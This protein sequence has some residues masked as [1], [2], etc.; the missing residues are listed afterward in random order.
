MK[1]L[2]LFCC[3]VSATFG[4]CNTTCFDFLVRFEGYKTTPY[5]L[6][7]VWHVG[8]GHKFVVGE[9]IR[10]YT[11]EEVLAL[12]V[13]DVERAKRAAQRK[14]QSFYSHPEKI[15]LVLISLAYN[16]GDKGFE[17]FVK[18]RAAMERGDYAMAAKELENSLWFNQLP[19]RARHHIAVIKEFS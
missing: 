8:I 6:N 14:I 1:K 3:L 18:F 7:G 9:P 11:D 5:R 2:L 15:R 10:E 13:S 4:Q 12:F 16:V 17:K 19:E